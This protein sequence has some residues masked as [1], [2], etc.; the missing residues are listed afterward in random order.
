MANSVMDATTYISDRLA[1][2][3]NW[4]D[5]QS[6]HCK[7]MH[8]AL[9][10][11]TAASAIA[12]P[13]ALAIPALTLAAALG[14]GAAALV[15]IGLLMHYPER[16]S[17]Y[18]IIA[19]E[20]KRQRVFA[21]LRGGPYRELTDAELLDRLVQHVEQFVSNHGGLLT[22]GSPIHTMPRARQR[23]RGE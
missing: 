9:S 21:E 5:G 12:I 23:H 6:Q 18:R 22:T 3:I 14:G 11:A 7:R 20:L 8:A 4:Y 17:R 15:G 10:L 16:W 13:V 2:Q 19:E 1:P